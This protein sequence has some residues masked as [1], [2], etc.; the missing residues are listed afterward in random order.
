[1]IDINKE[2]AQLNWNKEPRGLYEPIEYTLASGGKRLRPHLA[3]IAAEA[4]I[5]GGLINS[6]DDVLPAALAL[7]VFHNFTLVHDDVMDRAEVR[8]GQE[9]VHRKWNNNTS[10]LSGDQMLIEAYKL[11]AQVPAP[12]LPQVLKWF[13]E[14]ATGVCEGQQYDMEF[15]H[16]S[17]VS[18][19][20]YLKMIELKTSV[21][22]ANAM[23]IGGYIAGADHSQQEALYQYGL[24]IGI[25]FQIQDDILDVYG[26]PKTFGKAIGGDICCNKKTI[27]LLTALDTSDAESKAELLQWLMATDQKEE[28]IAAVTALYNR[29]GVREACEV[30]LE[31]YTSKALAQLDLLPANSATETLRELAE[32]LAIRKS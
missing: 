30:V 5:N 3:I 6:M 24:N 12:K 20:D 2:I 7:E 9:T 16:M 22:L 10:I 1:M 19:E 13:N 25:A 17:Q 14:M 8:R 31:E 15:E 27:L 32:Q 23:R 21:L 29:I 26:D 4:V 18:I 11:L 28:K